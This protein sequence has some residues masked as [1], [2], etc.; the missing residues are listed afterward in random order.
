[1][2]SI[3][4]PYPQINRFFTIAT[5]F[6]PYAAPSTVAFDG[7]SPQGGGGM[8]AAHRQR[9]RKPLLS[10][11]VESYGAQD[12]SGVRVAFSLVTFFWRSKRK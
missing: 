6:L 7:N 8:D 2:V 12:R 5:V 10:I 3:Y 9:G 4:H 11:P 1:M